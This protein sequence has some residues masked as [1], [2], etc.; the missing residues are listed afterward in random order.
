MAIYALAITIIFIIFPALLIL[1]VKQLSYLANEKLVN[2]FG[3]NSQ[4]YVG[5]LG[6]I[7]HELSH[8]LSISKRQSLQEDTL[9]H[10][11][12]ELL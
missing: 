5:G 6:V 11:R 10:L 2:T 8:L 7:I 12:G 9:I 1:L 3:F 4:I